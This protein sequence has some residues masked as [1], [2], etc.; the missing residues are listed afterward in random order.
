MGDFL[1]EFASN[2]QVLW[3][4]VVGIALTLPIFSYFFNR[5][6]AA[7]KNGQR[8]LYVVIGVL[9]TLAAVALLSWKAA[10][11]SLVMFALSGLFMIIGDYQRGLKKASQPQARIKRASYKVNGCLGEA[12][13]AAEQAN[14]HLAQAL[15]KHSE[16]AEMLASLALAT[17]ELTTLRLRLAEAQQIQK[18][19]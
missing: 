3:P 12:A 11:L 10:L 13:A 17:Q 14:R 2:L 7:D 5:I 9:V 1:N 16:P 19:G 15:K 8:S 18:E 4:L 6:V